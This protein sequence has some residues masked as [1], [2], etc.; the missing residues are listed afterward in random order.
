MG[1][2]T[3]IDVY[4]DDDNAAVDDDEE[5]RDVRQHLY[6]GVYARRHLG[7]HQDGQVDDG[8]KRERDGDVGPVQSRQRGFL[9]LKFGATVISRNTF[10]RNRNFPIFFHEDC[11]NF[12][13]AV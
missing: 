7:R 4:H 6:E 1:E 8:E 12:M 9:K 10:S 2:K 11:S 13:F 3:L 5:R